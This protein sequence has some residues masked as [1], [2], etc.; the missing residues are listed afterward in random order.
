MMVQ[1]RV[2]VGSAY[3]KEFK[4]KVGVHQGLVLLPLLLAIVVDATTENARRG[5]VNELLYAHDL[6]LMSKTMEDLRKKFWN[7]KVVLERKV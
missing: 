5:V 3:S 2:R 6:F 4:V 7:L 1:T